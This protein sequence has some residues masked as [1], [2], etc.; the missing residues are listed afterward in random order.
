MTDTPSGAVSNVCRSGD[1][2]ETVVM[3]VAEAKGVDP[4]ELDPLYDVIDPDALNSLF[5]PS[6]GSPPAP[7]DLRFSMAGCE[8]VVRGDGEVLVTPPGTDEAPTAPVMSK[9][10]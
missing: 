1:V 8:V 7:M 10:R 9:D 6:V 4:L 2:S 3:T 5:Q